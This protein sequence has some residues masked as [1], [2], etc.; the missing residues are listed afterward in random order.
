MRKRLTIQWLVIVVGIAV[1][2]CSRDRARNTL[3]EYRADANLRHAQIDRCK[4]DPGTLAK[5]PDC[6]NARQ[7]AVLEDRVRLRDVPPMGL[8]EKSPNKPDTDLKGAES[9]GE[10][11]APAR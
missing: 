4:A 2:G 11:A 8:S 9:T 6:I 10:S 7:A 1:A 3:D 5:T